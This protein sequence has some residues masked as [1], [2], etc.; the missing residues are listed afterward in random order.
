MPSHYRLPENILE[1]YNELK[2]AI[3]KRLEEFTQVPESEYFYEMCFCICTPQSK[4]TS[5]FKVQQLLKEADFLN[6]ELDPTPILRQPEHYI[7]FHNQ[8]AKRLQLL[9][10]QYPQL[11][12]IIKSK[13]LDTEK[14]LIIK[15]KVNGFGLKESAH[16][17]RNIGYKNQA[18]LDRHILKH[19]EYCGAKIDFKRIGSDRIYLETEQIFRDIAQQVNIPMDELDLL[20]WAYEA[21]E[22]LK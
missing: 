9:K 10:L 15:E 6:K 21:G 19:L 12:K 8:K 16:F 22:I 1:K 13:I 20:F 11:L 7:R 5:A 14:R 18:I 3:K 17:L 2:P 4:A